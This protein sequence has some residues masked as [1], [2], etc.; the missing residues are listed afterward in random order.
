VGSAD[1]FYGP[2]EPSFDVSTGSDWLTNP[3]SGWTSQPDNPFAQIPSTESVYGQSGGAGP[4]YDPTTGTIVKSATP[5][6]N[7]LGWLNLGNSIAQTVVGA[8][9]S[10]A[11]IYARPKTT[12]STPA[13]PTTWILIAG[14]IVLVLALF[15]GRK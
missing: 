7:L 13:S 2:Q 14:V 5:G 6:V 15:M 9:N 3:A 11:P 1:T 10:S 4:M 8:K 12:T